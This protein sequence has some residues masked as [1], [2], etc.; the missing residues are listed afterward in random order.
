MV[1]MLSTAAANTRAVVDLPDGYVAEID[2]DEGGNYRPIL[3]KDGEVVWSGAASYGEVEQ[4]KGAAIRQYHIESKDLMGIP[5]DKVIQVDPSL[6][7]AHPQN[8]VVYEGDEETT[9]LKRLIDVEKPY[10]SEYIITTE[11]V[12]ISGHRRNFV[13]DEI[14]YERRLKSLPTINSVPAIVKSYGSADEELKALILE[15]SY[16]ENKSEET[17]LREAMVL[18]EIEQR[19]ARQRQAQAR[20]GGV[21]EEKKGKTVEIVA[22]QLGFASTELRS[23][24]S[25]TETHIDLLENPELK[26]LWSELRDKKLNTAMT[27]RQLWDQE[28][29]SLTDEHF[30]LAIEILLDQRISAKKALDKSKL[31]ILESARKEKERQAQTKTRSQAKSKDSSGSPDASDASPD[32]E[33]SEYDKDDEY[34][35]DDEAT[36]EAMPDD[37][38]RE[39]WKDASEEQRRLWK[40][41]KKARDTYGDTPSNNRLTPPVLIERCLEV[42]DS[43]HFDYDPFADLTK[44]DHIPC[45]RSYTVVEDFLKKEKGEYV[46]P[47]SGN[48]YANILWN[49]QKDCLTALSY[50]IDKGNIDSMFVVSQ[51]S[52]LSLPSCQELIKKHGFVVISWSGR[53]EYEPGGILVHDCM[54]PLEGK[55]KNIPS[56]NQRYD[57]VVLFYSKE[58]DQKLACDRAFSDLALVTYQKDVAIASQLQAE[59]MIRLPVWT[60]NQCNW[61]GY[62]L[63]YILDNEGIYTVSI[64]KDGEPIEGSAEIESEAFYSDV[65]AKC[66]AM[67]KVM[68]FLRESNTLSGF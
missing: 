50:W 21:P 26:R 56:G 12:I 65:D 57:T 41:A 37:E 64:E 62:S 20:L 60:G 29:G 1:T 27:L 45:T 18:F 28:R 42:I 36:L 7:V 5:E 46:N 10:V 38:R 49:M 53:L 6:L 3:F 22:K 44:P 47:I 31:D 59:D 63:I 61:Y 52:I 2:A 24:I 40:I 39:W 19:N 25:L 13:I 34:D 14:N 48:V 30:I 4:A 32:D 11:G 33:Y 58:H 51:A 35:E 16:R 68:G 23:K 66:Y 15:N 8:Q 54:F 43:D 9:T 17:R 67:L 55:P